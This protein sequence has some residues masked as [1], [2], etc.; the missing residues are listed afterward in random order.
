M[1]LLEPSVQFNKKQHKK[2]NNEKGF[3]LLELVLVVAITVILAATSVPLLLN[4]TS[5]NRANAVSREVVSALRLAQKRSMS[6]LQD[7]EFGVYFDDSSKQFIVFRG[8]SYGLNPSDDLVFNYASSITISQSF[9]SSEVNLEKIT[10]STAD[11]GTIAITD[12]SGNAESISV[13]SQGKIELQ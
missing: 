8:A 9:S 11:T 3:T 2:K 12:T 13:S 6:G 1:S 5:R 4:V 7:S 10:G